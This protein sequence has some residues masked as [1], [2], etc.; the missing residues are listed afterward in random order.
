M[1]KYIYQS[2]KTGEEFVLEHGM[3]ESPLTRHPET[4]EAI[5]RIITAAPAVHVRG[6][7][8]HTQVNCRSP[9][10]TA[11]GCASNVALAKQMFADSRATPR[12]GSK[13]SRRTVTGGIGE[14]SRCGHT[15]RHG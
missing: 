14:I 13:E 10:A 2:C 1:P 4:G 9:A 11:C 3:M 6:L 7:K 8:K 15:H 12:Y 5:E